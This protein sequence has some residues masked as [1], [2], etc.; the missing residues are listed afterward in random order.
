MPELTPKDPPSRRS[1]FEWSLRALRPA[2]ADVARPSFMYTAGQAS[3]EK[4][5]RFWRWVAGGCVAL[6]V[7]VAALAV[8]VVADERGRK[9][10][11]VPVVAISPSTFSTSPTLPTPPPISPDYELPFATDALR[12]PARHPLPHD[13]PVAID[14]TP[15]EIA[16]ALA[17]RREVLIGGLGLIPDAKPPAVP[18][19]DHPFTL[20]SG[21]FGVPVSPKPADPR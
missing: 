21:V 5:V 15:R 1:A 6:A 13:V 17:R 14:P 20:T 3:R 4:A 16:A 18:S 10:Q 12:H 8:G 2:D 19:S 7:S 11:P 9:P